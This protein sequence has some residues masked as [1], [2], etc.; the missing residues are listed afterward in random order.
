MTWMKINDRRVRVSEI[1]EY[2]T[3]FKAGTPREGRH[4]ARHMAGCYRYNHTWIVDFV[5]KSGK[6]RHLEFED[7]AEFDA[8]IEELDAKFLPPSA[9]PCRSEGT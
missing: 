6:M 9:G 1:V 2:S 5:F 3:D 7:E 8:K 4:M